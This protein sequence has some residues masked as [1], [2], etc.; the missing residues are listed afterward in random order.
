MTET[1]SAG[2]RGAMASDPQRLHELHHHIHHLAADIGERS[3]HCPGSLER[4]A[5]YIHS[6]LESCNYSVREIPYPVEDQTVANIEAHLP[7]SDPQLHEL[8]IG[9]HYDT[10]PG[11]PGANDNG[12]GVAALLEIAR[13]LAADRPQR[14]LRLVAFVNEEPP[15]FRTELMGSRVYARQLA[16]AGVPLIGAIV[17][18]TI[19]YYDAT[20]GS[21]DYPPLFQYLYPDRGDFIGFVANRRSRP[22]MMQA[23]EAFRETSAFPAEHVAAPAVVPGVDWSDHASFWRHGYPA[24]MLTDTAPYRYPHY[25]CPTDT[26][27][28]IDY[29]ALTELTEGLIAMT[30]NLL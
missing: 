30:R 23:F 2:T 10:V 12:S 9:A 17:L 14:G 18:E 11:C 26:P 5:G 29:E 1:V 28:H 7:G 20:P 21:Q 24:L 19:G 8:V 22:F 13:A 4:S 15:F 3:L 16:E 25:H 27:E 6:H